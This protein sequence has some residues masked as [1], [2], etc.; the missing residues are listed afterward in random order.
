MEWFCRDCPRNCGVR[1]N[2]TAGSGYCRSAALPQVVRAAPHFGEEPC[3]SGTRGAGSIFFSGCNLRCIYCQNAEISRI[4]R[5][6]ALDAAGLRDLMLRL[7]DTGVHNIELITASH[8]TRVIAEALSSCRLS[9]PVVWNSSAYEKPETLRLLD[10]LVQVYLPDLKY[11]HAET[12]GRYSLA[13]D[14]PEIAVAAIDEMLRQRGSFQLDESGLLRSG[15]LIRHLILPG[16]AE[17]SRDVI[18]LVADRYPPGSVLF[19]LMSQYTPMP[20]AAVFPELSVPVSEEEN[21]ALIHYLS[22]RGLGDGYWQELSSSGTADI[23]PFD[24]TGLDF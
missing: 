9:V 10:G 11:L 16:N 24:G 17:E 20:S 7:Q 21:S 2:E 19:S 8:H 13:P 12:A 18:D 14:Y 4:P 1:R 5:G 6:R 22:V 23:P 15:V 3:I